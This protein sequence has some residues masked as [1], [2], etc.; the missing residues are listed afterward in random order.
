M[1]QAPVLGVTDL[2]CL[3]KSAALLFDK[4]FSH[5]EMAQDRGIPQEVTFYYPEVIEAMLGQADWEAAQETLSFLQNP[6]SKLEAWRENAHGVSLRMIWRGHAKHGIKVVP[7]YR[8]EAAFSAEFSSGEGVA[9]QAVLNN[10][11]VVAAQELEWQQILDFRQDTD[12]VRKYRAM[13]VWMQEILASKSLSEATDIV[14]TKLEDYKWALRKHGLRSAL[15]T[16]TE[17]I[18]SK[19]IATATAAGGVLALINHPS[20]ALLVTGSL[21]VSK[22][23]VSIAERKIESED[24]R[25]GDNS[26]IAVIHEMQTLVSSGR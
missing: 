4:I 2:S 22:V 24:L 1:S 10:L 21:V 12:A 20:L 5:R 7:L 9:Y 6:P 15:G 14:G 3:A 26:A 23:A 16:I 19:S 8:S 11:P 25:R 17:V 13:R 18:E